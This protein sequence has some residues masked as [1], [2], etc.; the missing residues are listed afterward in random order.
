VNTLDPN[1]WIGLTSVY[2]AHWLYF[3]AKY[4][5]GGP[6]TRHIFTNI[7]VQIITFRKN[8]SRTNVL[9]DKRPMD[10]CPYGLLSLWTIVLMDD[11]PYGLL[12]SSRMGV[13]AESKPCDWLTQK[14]QVVQSLVQDGA[15]SVIC[16]WHCTMQQ[17]RQQG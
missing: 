3:K 12:S 1:T 16:V 9:L 8:R 7:L 15:T 10:Y 13:C 11:C 14:T 2:F 17:R 5:S 6:V 4:I